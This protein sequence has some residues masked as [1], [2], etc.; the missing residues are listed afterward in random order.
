[1]KATIPIRVFN[2]QLD[3]LADIDAFGEFYY[4][5]RFLAPGDFALSMPLG[6]TEDSALKAGN[7]IVAGNSGKRIGIIVETEK[8]RLKKGTAWIIARG[9]EAKSIL[10]RRLVIP[11]E[12]S[13]FFEVTAPVETVM[14]TVVA[15]ECCTN[16]RETRKFE[17]LRLKAN[18]E[19][20]K[21]I[22][23]RCAFSNVLTELSRCGKATGTGF[24]IDFDASTRTMA[25]DILIGTDRSA[26]QETNGRALFSEDY[27]SLSGAN[28]IEGHSRYSNTLYMQGEKTNEGRIKATVW[29]GE[30]SSGTMR[31]ERELDAWAC[32]DDESLR[33]YGAARLGNYCT[34]FC[35]EAD[36]PTGSPIVLDRDYFLGDLCSVK[37]FDHWYTVPI[38]SIEERW[39]KDGPGIRLG[40]GRPAKGAFSAALA[41]TNELWEALRSG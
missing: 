7:F 5:R 22:S 1:M 14:K 4:V 31:F 30:E 35:L 2:E 24:M 38:E 23:L 9:Y 40:F 39:T 10:G 19:R 12:L 25:F 18:Q 29:D 41:E 6:R 15:R 13:G 21:Q 3:L 27:D 28:L 33:T 16:A 8:K 36:I 20:G 32:T 11:D 37:A 17:R 26:A 34:T